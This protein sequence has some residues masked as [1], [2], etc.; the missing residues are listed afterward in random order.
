M[1]WRV[2]IYKQEADFAISIFFSLFHYPITKYSRGDKVFHQ[3]C[4]TESRELIFFLIL[5]TP[6]VIKS[7]ARKLR[8]MY[9]IGI[10]INTADREI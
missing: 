8:K 1:A 10:Y 7:S 9:Y 6:R 4:A 3:R 2:G 5:Y